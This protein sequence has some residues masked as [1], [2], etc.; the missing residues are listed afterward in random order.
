L[1]TIGFNVYLWLG[2]VNYRSYV[3]MHIAFQF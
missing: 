1:A 3:F 2:W